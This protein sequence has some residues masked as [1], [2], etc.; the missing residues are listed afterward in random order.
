MFYDRE[1]K[2]ARPWP[3]EDFGVFWD[4]YRTPPIYL[5]TKTGLSKEK[6][7]RF[8]DPGQVV[9]MGNVSDCFKEKT[10]VA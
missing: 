4:A 6:Q 8:R 2:A 10:S 7:T 5:Q 1:T 9:A 3:E